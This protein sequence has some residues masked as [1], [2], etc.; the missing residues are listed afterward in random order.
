MD[1]CCKKKYRTE[2]EKHN[3]TVR[4]NRITGQIN[5]IK[6]M[7]NEDRYCYDIIVQLEASINGLKKIQN[8]M[9]KNHIST[10]VKTAISNGDETIL[11]EIK[12]L[13]KLS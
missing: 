1:D 10:C 12:E 9:L 8:D 3:L 13:L 4:L 11:E 7:I 5:G 6:N 2:E